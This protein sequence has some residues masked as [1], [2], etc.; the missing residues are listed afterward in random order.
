MRK[1]TVWQRLPRHQLP[2][3]GF[4]MTQSSM[5][6]LLCCTAYVFAALHIQVFLHNRH[7]YGSCFVICDV[8][9]FLFFCCFFFSRVLFHCFVRGDGGRGLF[10]SIYWCFLIVFFIRVEFFIREGV[11][12]SFFYFLFDI[13]PTKYYISNTIGQ[14]D[15]AFCGLRLQ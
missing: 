2:L 3:T 15:P 11:G 4:P 14:L 7:T 5:R 6:A 13:S 10:V 1:V 8:R 9:D 12:L